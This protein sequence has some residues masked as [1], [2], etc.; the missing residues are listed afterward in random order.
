MWTFS[1]LK[2]K[3]SSTDLRGFRW[4]LSIGG[5]V[6]ALLLY[7][8]RQQHGAAVAVVCAGLALALLSLVPGVGRWLFVGWMGLGLVLGRITTPIV[9]GA[10]WLI[11]F[12]PI[13]VV[14]PT[15]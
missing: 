4:I 15:P 2:R 8:A 9:F 1:D 10:V 5:L 13:S 6:I 12:I 14:L 11:L 7:F 3:P